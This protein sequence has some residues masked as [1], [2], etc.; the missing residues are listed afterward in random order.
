MT[1]STT[2]EVRRMPIVREEYDKIFT[3]CH[4][5]TKEEVLVALESGAW[6]VDHGAYDQHNHQYRLCFVDGSE[7]LVTVL[8]HE[9]D[10]LDSFLQRV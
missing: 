5:A 9:K 8:N 1:I 10:F 6:L 4:W 2:K 3:S 7:R